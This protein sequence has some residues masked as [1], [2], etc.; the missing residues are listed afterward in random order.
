MHGQYTLAGGTG[1]TLAKKTALVD[2]MR[3]PM[4]QRK[5]F[6]AK[7]LPWAPGFIKDSLLR[8]A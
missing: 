8:A 4:E 5:A 7:Q 1:S 6:I 2:F 3:W